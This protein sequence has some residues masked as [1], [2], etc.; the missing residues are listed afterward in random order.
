[1]EDKEF[2]KKIDEYNTVTDVIDG[3]IGGC[4]LLLIGYMLMFI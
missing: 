4:C 3:V 1:M 2:D